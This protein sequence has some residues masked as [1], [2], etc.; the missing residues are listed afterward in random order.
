[1]ADKRPYETTFHRDGTVT[2]WDVYSQ[3]WVRTRNPSVQLLASLGGDERGRVLAHCDP[4][5]VSD[6]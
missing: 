3:S 2:I 4:E 1:M 5:E 6:G